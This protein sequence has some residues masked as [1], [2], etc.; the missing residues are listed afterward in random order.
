MAATSTL[1]LMPN[2]RHHRFHQKAIAP[3]PSS[4]VDKNMTLNMKSKNSKAN[5]NVT[6]PSSSTTLQS[7]NSVSSSVSTTTLLH[8]RISGAINN[9]GGRKNASGMI[10]HPTLGYPVLPPQPAK[11]ARRN[12]RERNRVKQ[13]NSGFDHLRSHIPSAAKHKKMSKVDT[14]RHAVDYIESLTKML[15]YSDETCKSG[16]STTSSSVNASN[17][18]SPR[19]SPENSEEHTMKSSPNSVDIYSR[20]S[21]NILV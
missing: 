21:I 4:S 5:K 20:Y 16:I 6:T 9:R 18:I 8:N 11:V 10:Q 3:K 19:A 12:A 7:E 15:K 13:V 1:T 14:L 2:Q 17:K